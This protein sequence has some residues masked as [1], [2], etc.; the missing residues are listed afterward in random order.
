MMAALLVLATGALAGRTTNAEL[1]ALPVPGKVAIDG[2]LG[3]WNL[4]GGIFI[5]SDTDRLVNTKSAKA[6]LMYDGEFLYAAFQI[7]D[8]TPMVNHLDPA[9]EPGCGWK[10]DCI[11]LRICTDPEKPVG[12]G[13]A[14]VSH[15]DCYWFTDGQRPVMSVAHHDRGRGK[16]GFEDSI[17][18]ALAK[19]GEAAFLKDA[20]GNGY[21]QEL[22]IPWSL[23]RRDD[24]PGRPDDSFRMGI[25]IAWGDF[26]GRNV[27]L[28]VGDLVNPATPRPDILFAM[29][30]TWGLVTLQPA[31]KL[32]PSASFRVLAELS[33]PKGMRIA[34][35][36]GGAEGAV[37]LTFDDNLRDQYDNAAPWLEK[38][39]FRGTFFVVVGS[40]PDTDAEASAK[41]PGQAGGISWEGLK[42]LAERG[43]EIANHSWSHPALIKLDDAKLEAEVE[44]ARA[45]IAEKIGQPPLSFCYPGNGYD[46][47]V[48]EFVLR[49]HVKA[50]DTCTGYGGDFSVDEANARVLRT[51]DNGGWLVAMIH[52]IEAGYDAFKTP[53]NFEAHLK[54]LQGL[55]SRIW[56]DTFANIARYERERDTAQL[57]GT[58]TDAGA[59]FRL[60]CPLDPAVYNVP[61]TVAVSAPGARN[62]KAQL[63]SGRGPIPVGELPVTQRGNVIYVDVAPSKQQV[64]VT[65]DAPAA[66]P[67]EP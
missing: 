53:A 43:H 10:S 54:F 48:R 7:K 51:L 22:Q 59:A 8:R 60:T 64:W 4:S 49:H 21:T 33:N 14:L 34:Q 9:K 17:P 41:K 50:R 29:P 63:I 3:D 1:R 19:S 35:F 24:R 62:P 40:T 25:D 65:W 55:G 6:Y 15:V 11:Q 27:D 56:V 30:K 66:L 45:R 58:Q 36:K 46:A 32:A 42:R 61:L 20:D 31:G 26:T 57:E 2:K 18:D 5:C 47:R 44:K 37:S 38:Y 13:G 23:L 39:G 16:D 12:P 52:G 28:F 67:Q